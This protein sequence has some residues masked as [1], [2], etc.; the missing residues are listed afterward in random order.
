MRPEPS[1]RRAFSILGLLRMNKSNLIGISIGILGL[2]AI[3]SLI[4][5]STNASGKAIN[6]TPSVLSAVVSNYDFGKVPIGGG[7][8]RHSYVLRNDTT[9]PVVISKI[10]TSCMCTEAT[11][12]IADA[13]FGPYRMPGHRAVPSVDQVLLPGAEVSIDVVFDPAAH[14]PAG[15][16]PVSRV[17]SIEDGTGGKVDLGFKALITP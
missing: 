14:G 15:I 1:I 4:G 9:L 12:R 3:T 6:D 7:L 2:L 13:T 10:Y 16:G 5:P 17:V 11:L 8:V